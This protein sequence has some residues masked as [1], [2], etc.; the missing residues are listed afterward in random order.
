MAPPLSVMNCHNNA[1]GQKVTNFSGTEEQAFISLMFESAALLI[2]AGFIHISG[3]RLA[4][5]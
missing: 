2:L 4:V 1:V 5:G 3:G